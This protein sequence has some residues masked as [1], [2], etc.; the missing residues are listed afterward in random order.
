MAYATIAGLPVQVGLYT[1]M[2]PMTVYALIGGSRTLSVSMIATLTAS[3]LVAAG[4]A[5]GSDDALGDLAT[6]T[7]LAGIVLLAPAW[8]RWERE[9]R[10]QPTVQAA[11]RA[12][13]RTRD[14]A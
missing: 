9:G 10:V 4:V 2:V 5:T 6:L 13:L 8:D 7:F 11:I 3:T 14:S 12:F 1:C